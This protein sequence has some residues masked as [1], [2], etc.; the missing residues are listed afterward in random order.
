MA[1]QLGFD[2]PYN[3]SRRD[4]VAFDFLGG[5]LVDPAVHPPYRLHLNTIM[6]SPSSHRCDETT[7]NGFKIGKVTVIVSHRCTK[8]V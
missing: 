4:I 3:Y 1:P 6:S 7:L 2:F 5:I 8:Q